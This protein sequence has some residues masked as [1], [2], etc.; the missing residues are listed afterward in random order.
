MKKPAI[1]LLIL[2]AAATASAQ[3]VKVRATQGVDLAKYKTYAWDNGSGAANPMIGQLVVD[4]VNQELASKGLTLVSSDPEIT[5]SFITGSD[6]MLQTAGISNRAMASGPSTTGLPSV[7]QSWGVTKGTLL[8]NI[9]DART[10]DALWA[11]TATALL[12]HNPS[13]DMVKDA[14][15]ADK[16]IK[17]AVAKMFKQYPK[18]SGN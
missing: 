16:N 10:K 14:R 17:K 18:I 13:G 7:S 8:V 2:V 5:V 9:A 6:S 15:R 11:A 12:E 3:K 4:A 1:I